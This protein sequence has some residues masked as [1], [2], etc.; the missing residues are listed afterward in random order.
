MLNP[1][2]KK[3]SAGEKSKP[4]A[5]EA[6]SGAARADSKSGGVRPE[7]AKGERRIVGVIMAPHR[8]E[9]TNLATARGW[10]T[11]R[12]RSDASKILVKQA[13]QDRY[14]VGVEAVRIV[15]QRPRKRRVGRIQG[16]TPGF[17]KAIVRVKSGETIETE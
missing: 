2:K 5:A 14:G 8:T 16:E 7:R 4:V 11:F 10:Y 12:V 1:F 13:V 15:N 9:K 17:K 3:I 6:E